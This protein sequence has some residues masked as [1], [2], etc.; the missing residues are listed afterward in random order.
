MCKL[1]LSYTRYTC[2]LTLTST[3]FCVACIASCLTLG[4]LQF[5]ICCWHSYLIFSMKSFEVFSYKIR[6]CLVH[7]SETWE[8]KYL[9]E[10][11]LI[12][13]RSH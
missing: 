6:W 5:D 2:G 7:N 10:T 3:S 1:T 13:E 8:G 4:Y 11:S 9:K 12:F